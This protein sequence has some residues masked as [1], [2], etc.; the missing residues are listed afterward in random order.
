MTQYD[1]KLN[2]SAFSKISYYRKKIDMLKQETHVF[3]SIKWKRCII[4][5]S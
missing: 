5:K 2:M 3:N 4:S 1:K